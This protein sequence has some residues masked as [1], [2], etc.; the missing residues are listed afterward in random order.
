MSAQ[1]MCAKYPSLPKAYCS[2]CQGTNRQTTPVPDFSL[3]EGWYGRYSIVEV[4]KN[5][6]PIHS[7]DRH[8][9]FGVRKAELILTSIAPIREFAEARDDDERRCFRARII[10]GRGLRVHVQLE[11]HPEFETST[12]L[13]VDRPYLHLRALPPVKG[14]I[15]IG[16]LK[17]RAICAV[18]LDLEDWLRR[19]G[20][21]FSIDSA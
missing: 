2:H 4:L 5:G 13:K 6:G 19:F 11:M 17:C 3:A 8:F 12:R 18:E 10:A 16:V 9:R 1:E 7:W 21:G 14:G 15:G 20:T